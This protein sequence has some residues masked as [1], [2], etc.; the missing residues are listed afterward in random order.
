MN[1]SLF[2]EIFGDIQDSVQLFT[3]MILIEEILYR[4]LLSND[5]EGGRAHSC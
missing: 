2:D 3:S 1:L 4:F 5:L